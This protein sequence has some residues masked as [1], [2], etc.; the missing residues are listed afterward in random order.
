MVQAK[1]HATWNCKARLLKYKEDITPFAKDGREAEFHKL[2]KPFEVIEMEGN[3]LLN[4]GIN[5]MW[6]LITG[7]VSGAEHIFDITSAKIGVGDS[8]DEE[9]AT[10]SGLQAATNK[11]HK[12]MESGYPTSLTQK[13][14]FKA[15]F[16]SAD[17]NYAW[18]EWV[19]Q[20]TGDAGIALNRKVEPLGTKSTGTWT[21][22]VDITLS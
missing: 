8:A 18:N 19:V 13:A 17:A 5:E 11:C 2:F 20:H 10:E 12:G 21:L 15:S 14:T 7:V 6:D 3:C 16:G 9:D 1:E 4:T 22:E